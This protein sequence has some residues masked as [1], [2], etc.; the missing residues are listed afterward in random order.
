[1][2]LVGGAVVL[3]G[4]FVAQTTRREPAPRD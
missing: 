1:V 4:I 2:Q 3:T